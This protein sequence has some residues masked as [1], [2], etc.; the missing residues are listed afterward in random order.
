MKKPLPNLMAALVATCLIASLGC[1]STPID[2]EAAKNEAGENID[3]N[4][5]DENPGEIDLKNEPKITK[6]KKKGPEDDDNPDE[7]E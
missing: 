4:E 2:P 7:K 3:S 1:D 5:S 6:K